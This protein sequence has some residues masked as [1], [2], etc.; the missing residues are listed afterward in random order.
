MK[1]TETSIQLHPNK[2]LRAMHEF[3]KAK[4]HYNQDN[5]RLVLAAMLNRQRQQLRN[6][7]W[8]MKL[9]IGLRPEF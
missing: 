5:D 7:F 2:I 6:A 3:R 9:L 1:K 4:E 8:S